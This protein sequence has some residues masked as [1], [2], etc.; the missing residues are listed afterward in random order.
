[1]GDLPFA[2]LTPIDL[3]DA[4]HVLTGLA[5]DRRLCPF[6][7]RGISDITN[8]VRSYDLVNVRRAVREGASETLEE[9][10]YRFLADR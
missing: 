10:A 2:V 3:S 8:H 1:M 4:Q 5:P 6:V 9:I 7:P